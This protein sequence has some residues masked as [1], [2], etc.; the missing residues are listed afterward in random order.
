MALTRDYILISINKATGVGFSIGV[1][2]YS[3]VIGLSARVESTPVV[4][5]MV[6]V[7]IDSMFR[8]VPAE[9][10]TFAYSLTLTN[11]TG[12]TQVVDWW[13]KVIRPV[14]LP[15]D[16]LSGPEVVVLDRFETMVIDTPQLTVPF[17]ARTGEY[18]LI[19]YIGRYLADT[20]GTDTTDFSKLPAIPCEDISRFQARCRPGGVMQARIIVTDN[21]HLGDVAEFTIDDVPY[22]AAVGANRIAFLSLTGFNPGSHEVA[23]TEP[24]GCYDPVTVT[25]PA[26]L[27]S[28]PGQEWETDGTAEVVHPTAL[29]GNFPDPFNPA[30]SIRYSLQEDAHISLQVFNML[31]QKVATL[32][33]EQRPPGLH[34]VV[35][36]GANDFGEKV[37]SGI[38]LYRIVARPLDG[39]SATGFTAT[40]KMIL[41][42]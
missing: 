29:L 24:P 6:E 26:G 23:L 41:M 34:E 28:D 31:G 7:E 17:N 27:D 38:Y 37:A 33:D 21:S 14:G 5:V 16:P 22:E 10:D 20:L 1:I 42:K 30:T 9:G 2:G 36:N 25:C 35:W 19:A 32:V 18:A 8:V 13:T 11:N 15:I 40:R 39:G 12:S 4:P 3:A